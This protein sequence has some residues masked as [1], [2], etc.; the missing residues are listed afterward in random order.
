MA[1]QLR[2][3]ADLNPASLPL[4]CCIMRR[5]DH[6]GREGLEVFA[7]LSHERRH[8]LTSVAYGPGGKCQV[9]AVL[10]RR[11]T[12]A[13]SR[14]KANWR[15]V[16]V[17]FDGFKQAGKGW[18]YLQSWVNPGATIGTMAGLT[19]ICCYPHITLSLALTGLVLFMVLAYPK[20]DVGKPRP[21]EPD[22][23]AEEAE[24]D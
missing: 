22:P 2:S 20:Q 15:R 1:L 11:D 16:A 24:D 12:F 4:E 17:W 14:V 10:R 23:D 3:L 6:K 8:C 7:D 18:K 13:M 9:A 21:M 19:S 5:Q